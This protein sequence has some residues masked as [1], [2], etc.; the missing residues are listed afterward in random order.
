MTFR[1]GQGTDPFA[2]H[3][4]EDI[5]HPLLFVHVK[6]FA[7]K[8]L[9]IGVTASIV[10]GIR[11]A[12]VI[13]AELGAAHLALGLFKK[14]AHTGMAIP[15]RAE[16][17]M[18]VEEP[19]DNAA[20]MGEV[21]DTVTRMRHQHVHRHHEPHGVL[22]AHREE[23]EHQQHAVREE[24]VIG[25]KDAHERSRRTDNR[26]VRQAEPE[27]NEAEHRGKDS[28]EQVHRRKVL[29]AHHVGN[30]AA[31]HPEHEHI[32][33]EMPEIHMHEHVGHE[34]PSLFRSKRP[35]RPQVGDVFEDVSVTEARQVQV[36]AKDP[37]AHK[38]KA[39]HRGIDNQQDA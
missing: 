33:N 34:P 38:G 10:G 11:T 19:C 17:E 12:A 9:I 8:G 3:F 25:D 24:L 4:L 13:D 36:Q 31:E 21:R 5:I 6:D 32:E 29:R 35:E 16:V 20:Q 27:H 30:L 15:Q 14:A 28:A 18:H 7:F 26:G 1:F 37:A 22:D 2:A 39:E 23:E